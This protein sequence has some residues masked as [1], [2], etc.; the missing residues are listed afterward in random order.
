MANR[1]TK[2]CST[3]P[4]IRERQIKTTMRHHL[5]PVRTAR[6]E[7][8]EIV[9]VS[10]DVEKKEP[11]CTV[12]RNVN[13]PLE[14]TGWKCFEKLKAEKQNYHMSQQFHYWVFTQRKQKH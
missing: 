3:S 11:S 12:V 8:Q 10:E 2:R 5:P 4:I 1:D 7:T 13:W 14:N 6:I 9:S